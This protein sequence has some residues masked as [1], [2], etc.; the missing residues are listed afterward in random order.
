VLS[1]LITSN[2]NRGNHPS[3]VTVLLGSPESAG[4]GLR[5]DSVIMTDNIVTL[6]ENKIDSVIGAISDMKEINDALRHSFGL[7]EN[8][9]EFENGKSN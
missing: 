3:R 7:K 8:I 4:S 1:A 2:I 6:Q 5:L 9:E